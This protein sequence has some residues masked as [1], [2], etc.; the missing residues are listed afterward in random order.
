MHYIFVGD[1]GF[2]SPIIVDEGSLAISRLTNRRLSPQR[3]QSAQSERKC[4]GIEHVL[5]NKGR[6][7][8]SAHVVQNS[9]DNRWRKQFCIRSVAEPSPKPL[10]LSTQSAQSLRKEANG[11]TRKDER[12]SRTLVLMALAIFFASTS[13][14]RPLQRWFIGY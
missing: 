10:P 12:R 8:S 6:I 14:T 7:C 1:G 9:A 2:S 5:K 11:E 13:Y 3:T 4:V